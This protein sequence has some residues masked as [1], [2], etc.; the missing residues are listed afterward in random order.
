M[1]GRYTNTAGPEELNDRFRVPIPDSR[2]THRFNVA[3]T[4]EVLA[5]VAPKGEPQAEILRWGLIPSWATET[6]G[7][8]KMI[9]ARIET[10]T[11]KPAYRRL[12]PRGERRALQIADGYFEWL[13]PERK[14]EPR[15]PFHFQV[16][17]GVPFA[18][19]AI[20]TPAKVAGEWLHSISLL[21]C[22]SRPNRTAAAIH[23]R[24]PVI[25]ADADAQQAWL[26]PSLDA[27]EALALCGALPT[28]RLSAKAANPAVNKVVNPDVPEGPELLVAPLT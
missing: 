23:N 24:M 11:E 28:E 18:F 17:G 7:A 12:I 4:E 16:D 2:G 26:D 5:I 22:D 1:C 8:A 6:K 10:V 27:E 21:T 15:Q 19:A 20:W 13:K 3:P 25:L 14:G 9:N